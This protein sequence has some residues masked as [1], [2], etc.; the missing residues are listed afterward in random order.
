MPITAAHPG[1]DLGLQ[2]NGVK[3]KRT[4]E[5]TTP[6]YHHMVASR[7]GHNGDTGTHDSYFHACS[8]YGHN[9]GTAIQDSYFHACS[10]HHHHTHHKPQ[11][12]S[13]APIA[14]EDQVGFLAV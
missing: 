12:G 6:G 4:G 9:G 5:R 3:R 13:R 2:V 8:N 11:H 14:A 1:S 10:N 7:D